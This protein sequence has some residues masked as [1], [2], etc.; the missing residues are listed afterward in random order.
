MADYI[1]PPRINPGS[2]M[3][4]CKCFGYR[5]NE[6]QSSNFG[7]YKTI[8]TV[9]ELFLLVKAFDLKHLEFS[10]NLQSIILLYALLHVV[11]DF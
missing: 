2:K 7:R 6:A 3:F 9:F 11:R 1:G 4:D 8:L 5:G 10:Y